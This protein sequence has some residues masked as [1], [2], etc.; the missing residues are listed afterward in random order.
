MAKEPNRLHGYFGAA[1]AAKAAGNK[2]LA[3]ANYRKLVELTA[4]SDADRSEVRT[5]KG[6]LAGN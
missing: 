4:G 5:A 2:D 3:K 1:E 6:Y